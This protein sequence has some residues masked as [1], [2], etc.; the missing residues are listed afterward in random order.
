MGMT[1]AEDKKAIKEEWLSVPSRGTRV[2][3]L[4][5]GFQANVTFDKEQSDSFMFWSTLPHIQ[6]VLKILR[7]EQM[8]S[9]N[10]LIYL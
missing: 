1:S 8:D 9:N 2:V 6:P 4:G 7:V 5:M 10:V 3:L